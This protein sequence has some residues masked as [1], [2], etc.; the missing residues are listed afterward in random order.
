VLAG[1]C[2]KSPPHYT[3][4]NDTDAGSCCSRCEA[5]RAC[6]FWTFRDPRKT[7]VNAG[8]FL[9]PAGTGVQRADPL[10][11]SGYGSSPPSP[12]PPLPPLPPLPPPPPLPPLPPI[13]PR[14]PNLIPT[15][16]AW[17]VRAPLY[18]CTWQAQGRAWMAGAS[19]LNHTAALNYWE[20][21]THQAWMDGC[22]SANLFTNGSATAGEVGWAYGG[23]ESNPQSSGPARPAYA[24]GSLHFAS[25]CRYTYPPEARREL[26]LMLDNGWQNGSEASSRDLV[27]NE[28]RF[29]EF[30]TEPP[31]PTASLCLLREKVQ[32]LGWRGLGVWVNGGGSVSA[33]GFSRLHDAGVGLLKFDGGDAQCAMTRLAREHAP[34]L[35]VEHGRCVD[36]CPLNGGADG[37]GTTVSAA[38]T[39]AQAAPPHPRALPPTCTAVG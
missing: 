28:A 27:L 3:A 29:P 22:S 8:C 15:G 6:G 34:A 36:G 1:T 11:T 35:L 30:V 39:A 14:S 16:N 21:R 25:C 5:D 12:T 33:A 23:R 4:F 17:H 24:S 9:K 31:D 10:C 32:A 19:S 13:D 7:T 20:A 18:W 2:F 37:S 26:F 38:D